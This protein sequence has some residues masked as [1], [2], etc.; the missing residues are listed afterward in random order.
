LVDRIDHLL[1]LQQ[2]HLLMPNLKALP[3]QQKVVPPVMV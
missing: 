2:D 3:P 1:V